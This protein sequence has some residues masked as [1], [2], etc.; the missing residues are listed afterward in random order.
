MIG[1]F[2]QNF[3]LGFFGQNHLFIG[4]VSRFGAS[5][6]FFFEIGDATGVKKNGFYLVNQHLSTSTNSATFG[7]P[8]GEI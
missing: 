6:D 8:L 2:G 7:N 3:K 5:F 4:P 1:G